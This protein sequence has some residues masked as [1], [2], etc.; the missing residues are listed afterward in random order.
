MARTYRDSRPSAGRCGSTNPETKR[1]CVSIRRVTVVGACLAM[2]SACM[3]VSS[4]LILPSV[5]AAAAKTTTLAFWTLPAGTRVTNQFPGIVFGYPSGFPIDEQPE[6]CGPPLTGGGNGYVSIYCGGEFGPSGL[7]AE[8]TNF[9]EEVSAAVGDETV[10]GVTFQ[11]AAYDS[12]RKLIGSTEV[13]S[14]TEGAFTPISFKAPG[15]EIAYFAIV[16]I[17]SPNYS[18]VVT[19]VSF[20]WGEAPPAIT[21]SPPAGGRIVPGAQVKRQVSI[22]RHNGSEG[23]VELK[24]KGLPSGMSASFEPQVLSGTETTSTLTLTVAAAAPLAETTGV[25]EA[26]PETVQAG[27]AD[28]TTPIALAV[29]PPFSVYAGNASSIPA[30]TTVTEAP[31]S[32]VGVRVVTTSGEGFAGPVDL[33]LSTDAQAD[34]SSLS[35]EKQV[36]TPAELGSGSGGYNEQ[37]LSIT[38]NG[39]GPATGSFHVFVTGSSGSL[40][41]P[42]ATVEVERVPGAISRV[43]STGGFSTPSAVQTP[44]LDAPGSQLTLT[45]V[46]FCPGTRVA[47]GD[48]DTDPGTDDTATPESIAPNGTSLTFRVPPGAVSGPVY[49][50]PPNGPDIVGPALTV[51]SFRSTNGFKFA[52]PTN[53]VTLD[54]TMV[55]EIFGQGETNYNIFGWLVRKPEALLFEELANKQIHGGLCF[56][57]AYSSLEFYDKPNELAGFPSEAGGD[58]WGLTGASAPSPQLLRFLTE[59]FVLQFTENLIP[60]AVNALIGIHGTNDDIDAIE[61]GLAEGQPVMVSMTHWNGASYGGGHTVLAYETHPEPDG[62]TAVDVVNSN[63]PYTTGEESNSAEHD[64][65][66]FTKSQIIIANG[67]WEFKEGADFSGSNGLP[68]TGSEADMVVYKHSELPIINGQGPKLPNLADALAVNWFGSAGDTVTQLSGGGRSLLSGGQMAPASAWPKGVAPIPSFSGQSGPLQMVAFNPEVAAPFTV[69]VKRSA[70]GGAMHMNLPGLQA[71]LQTAAH[72]GQIDH[73]SVD[74]RTDTIGYQTSATST[75]LEGTLLS[76]ASAAAGAQ[77][78]ASTTGALSDHLVQFQTTAYHGGD[79]QL[80]FAGGHEFVLHHSGPPATLAVSLSALSASGQPIAVR[81]PSVRLASGETL[82][83]A[84]DSWKALRSS[85]VRLT[86]SINRHVT[87]RLIRGHTLGR[88]F[89][90]IRRAVLQARGQSRYRVAVRLGV[91]HA[92]AHAWLS[93]AATL[94]R[95]GHAVVQAA[96]IQLDGSTLEAGDVYLTLPKR[97]SP[98]RQRFGPGLADRHSDNVC[99]GTKGVERLSPRPSAAA[100][101]SRASV[102]HCAPL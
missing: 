36:L 82:S 39:N 66:E 62:S 29:V 48:P 97:L 75:P 37:T 77:A 16:A 102:G 3:A 40:N 72:A 6:S 63:E 70:G 81:L 14:K 95:G 90:S 34:V 41:E 59:R 46:G 91:S 71:S 5:A 2:L 61:A 83:V 1:S 30:S 85:P 28:A 17:D 27:G 21:L 98:G 101:V 52:N 65:R 56:G 32:T 12:E 78:S 7:F 88:P 22:V 31:C 60:A 11:L 50:L 79:E 33:A 25:L 9:A 76:A 26:E 64:E 99:R 96:P 42:A 18:A 89:A 80:A 73:V 58:A 35:L 49:V 43:V 93:L 84:P 86:T 45:G 20:L 51:Q 54:Q 55:D 8:F 74:P 13:T 53:G 57:M 69:T 92:P 23:D 19:D 44:A 68:W 94:T 67:N 4:L 87:S 15:Y 47:V 38:R 24:A 100:R 10:S